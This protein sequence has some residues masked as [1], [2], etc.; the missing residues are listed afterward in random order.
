[1]PVHV[2]FSQQASLCAEIVVGTVLSPHLLLP[3]G[4]G[5]GNDLGESVTLLLSLF[6]PKACGR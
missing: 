1:M 6:N 5:F 4:G 3:V 2:L